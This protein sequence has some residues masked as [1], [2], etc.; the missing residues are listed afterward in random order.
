M[1]ATTANDKLLPR[2]GAFDGATALSNVAKRRR[3]AESE[4]KKQIL[5]AAVRKRKAQREIKPEQTVIV[6]DAPTVSTDFT[7]EHKTIAY[8][9][10][11]ESKRFQRGEWYID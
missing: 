5:A 9:R 10:V 3:E 4:S 2:D 1:S 6:V 7:P 8:G 11:L